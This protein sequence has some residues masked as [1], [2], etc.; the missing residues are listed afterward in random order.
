MST[1]FTFAQRDA[2]AEL[3]KAEQR[4]A[5]A[6]QHMENPGAHSFDGEVNAVVSFLV[7]DSVFEEKKAEAH[8]A[9]AALMP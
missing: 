6:L 3:R 7:A 4:R 5:K 8:R 9:F 2:A 1:E